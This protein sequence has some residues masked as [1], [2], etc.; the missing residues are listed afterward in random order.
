MQ[1]VF[2]FLLN[3]LD[4]G[5]MKILPPFIFNP[6]KDGGMS[7]L[8]PLFLKFKSAAKTKNI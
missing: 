2:S 3:C 5:G 7:I 6:K 1:N 4:E 8:K